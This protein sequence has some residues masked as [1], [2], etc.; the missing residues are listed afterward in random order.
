MMCYH[1][2]RFYAFCERFYRF[3]IEFTALD[4]HFAIFSEYA[5]IFTDFIRFPNVFTELRTFLQE[6][7]WKR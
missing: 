7:S 2:Y 5:I 6:K 1:F 4:E 3:A